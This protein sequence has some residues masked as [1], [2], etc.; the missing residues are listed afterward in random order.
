MLQLWKNWTLTN[1]KKYSTEDMDENKLISLMENF[2]GQK[3]QWIK[4]DRPELL[5]KM[6]VCRTIEPR[7]DRFLAIFDD[8]SSI[9]SAS[10]NTSL[11]MIHGD[12]QPLSREEVESISG[13]KRAPLVNPATPQTAQ[14]AQPQAQPVQPPVQT[15]VQVVK[16]N[17]FE[18][19]NSEPTQLSLVLSVKLPEKKLL[20][21]MYASA[22][23]KDEFLSELAE[24]LQAMINKQVIQKSMAEQLAPQQLK[25]DT[26]RPTVNL[27]EI[28]ESK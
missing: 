11:L 16:P 8:G 2:K 27:R 17:M 18:L 3:F 20:K 6:V 14:S 19:F 21:M 12:M 28:D 5:G 25:K 10:L 1:N 24:Y 22:E 26:V 9:D 15:P 13:I 4:T 7:G 23:N